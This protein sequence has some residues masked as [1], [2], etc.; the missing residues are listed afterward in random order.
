MAD[1][2]E[3][4]T[5]VHNT[6]TGGSGNTVQ[7]GSISGGIH[8]HINR[9]PVWVWVAMSAAFVLVA[10]VV[11]LVALPEQSSVVASPNSA[12]EPGTT[13]SPPESTTTTETP[14]ETATEIT[15]TIPRTTRTTPRST[16]TAPVRV[17]WSGNL[18]LGGY[19]GTGGGWWLDQNPPGQAVTGD[20]YFGNQNEV[21]GRALVAWGA[22]GP[23]DQSHCA[24]LLTTNLGQT[25]VD[26]Q[27]GSTA[28]FLTGDG[29]VGFFTVTRTPGPNE[30]TPSINIRATVWEMR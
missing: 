21:A 30:L 1:E 7:A 19:G 3:G 15:S 29:R 2:P 8:F 5:S 28:C 17:R 14:P 4:R 24:D 10:V 23:P 26:V 9:V 6:T 22:D 25:W 12:T 18:K 13:T 27:V 20:L 16:T 11:V